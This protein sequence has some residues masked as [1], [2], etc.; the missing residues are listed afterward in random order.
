M[1]QRPERC[2]IAPATRTSAQILPSQRGAKKG[3]KAIVELGEP[4]AISCR[5]NKSWT[6]KLQSLF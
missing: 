4:E 3:D 6:K 2:G 1:L 5:E